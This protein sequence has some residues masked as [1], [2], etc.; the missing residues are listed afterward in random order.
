[1][2]ASRPLSIALTVIGSASHSAT[3]SVLNGPLAA[4]RSAIVLITVFT[5]FKSSP[6]LLKGM[7]KAVF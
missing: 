2:S 5:A 7:E 3:S 1:V 6:I 4:V